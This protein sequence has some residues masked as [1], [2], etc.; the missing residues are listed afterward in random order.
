M[1]Y[2]WTRGHRKIALKPRGPQGSAGACSGHVCANDTAEI[3]NDTTAIKDD[4]AQILAEIARLQERLPKQVENDYI[5]QHF[6]EDMTTYTEQ[7][8]DGPYSDGQSPTP[9]VLEPEYDPIRDVYLEDWETTAVKSQENLWNR[10][11][12]SCEDESQQQ[13]LPITKATLPVG[14]AISTPQEQ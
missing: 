3:R 5:L 4:T 7:T 13:N 11:N 14:R 10:R 1:G 9:T 12:T 2:Q 6:L 8:L